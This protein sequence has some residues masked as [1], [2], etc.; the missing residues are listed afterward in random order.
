MDLVEIVSVAGLAYAVGTLAVLMLDPARRPLET[1][2]VVR[3]PRLG[4]SC[5]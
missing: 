1:R 3:V 4:R 5:T 2:V